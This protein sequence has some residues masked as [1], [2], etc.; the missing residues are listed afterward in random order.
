[1]RS[2]SNPSTFLRFALAA[3]LTVALS[4]PAWAASD[5]GAQ[6]G[7]VFEVMS[8]DV[9]RPGEFVEFRIRVENTRSF[10]FTNLTVTSNLSGLDL[11]AFPTTLNT[12]SSVVRDV[13]YEVQ[14]GDVPVINAEFTLAGT[15]EMGEFGGDVPVTIPVNLR[16]GVAAIEVIKKVDGRDTIAIDPGTLVT[17]T[18]EVRNTGGTDLFDVYVEDVAL[19]YGDFTVDL[20]PGAAATVT[21]PAHVHAA[22]DFASGPFVNTAVVTACYLKD[23]FDRCVGEVV[24]SDTARVE[25][26][27]DEPHVDLEVE[28]TVDDPT[29]LEGQ[30]VT[31]TVTVT[32]HG[33][34]DADGVSLSDVLPAGLSYAGHSAGQGTYDPAAGEW[35]VGSLA[36]GD[37]ATLTLRARV[38]AG[39][40][41]RTLTNT[42]VMTD[43]S[44]DDANPGNDRDSAS[45]VPRLPA[46][47]P[48]D[49]GQDEAD[50]EPQEAETPPLPVTGGNAAQLVIPG[51]LVLGA[52]LVL[53]RFGF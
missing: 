15:V 23:E 9:T 49:E 40:A 25:R 6:E 14:P 29:P 41:G 10:R 11:S 13:L 34:D 35:F 33:P 17:Y 16:I 26:L 39:T 5:S 21:L 36:A 24:G 42:A 3:L 37:S 31:F 1:L 4:V 44:P 19:G 22:A 12:S 50:P 2:R 18:V 46:S 38:E 48:E 20:S 27:P 30:E 47:E 51:L 52:G 45:V 7:I 53:R 32:N 43:S 28:K 8:T